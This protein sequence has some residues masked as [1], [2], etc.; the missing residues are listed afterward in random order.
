MKNTK[1]F[2]LI[3]AIILC[4]TNLI[5]VIVAMCS[6]EVTRFDMIT[7]QLNSFLLSGIVLIDSIAF[8]KL[9]DKIE[10][11]DDEE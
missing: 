4:V 9:S 11:E 2:L 1:W 3:I 5:G 8:Y 6:E 7:S 10:D